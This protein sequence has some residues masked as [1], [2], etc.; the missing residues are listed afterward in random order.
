MSRSAYTIK[1]TETNRRFLGSQLRIIFPFI[2]AA[3]VIFSYVRINVLAM[4][5][6]TIIIIFTN[7]IS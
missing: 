4:I 6:S 7:W 2:T 5:P 3:L 1:D